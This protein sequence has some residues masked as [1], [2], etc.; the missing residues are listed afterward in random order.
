MSI[1]EKYIKSSY[2][3]NGEIVG[4]EYVDVSGLQHD[5]LIAILQLIDMDKNINNLTHENNALNEILNGGW[6][7]TV[8]ITGNKR[9]L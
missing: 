3:E 5:T 6:F 2:D 8:L 4:H 9:E 7:I 1:E